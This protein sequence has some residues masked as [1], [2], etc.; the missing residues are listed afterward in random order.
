M[1]N[2]HVITIKD[3]NVI[4]L[5]NVE[6]IVSFDSQEFLINTS[7]GQLHIKGK[8]LTIAKMDTDNQILQIKGHIDY[9]NYLDGKK[10]SSEPVKKEGFFTKLF[11]WV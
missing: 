11:K 3:R 6:N 7:D 1:E 8:D 10:N 5:N 2:N 4:D 9:L